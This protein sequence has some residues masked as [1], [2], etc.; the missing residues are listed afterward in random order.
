MA[1]LANM[2]QFQTGESQ[3][4]L[5]ME[6]PI[7]YFNWDQRQQ[8]RSCME[9]L[10]QALSED[11]VNSYF[12][13]SKRRMFVQGEVKGYLKALPAATNFI[14][15]ADSLAVALWQLL[16]LE[17]PRNELLAGWTRIFNVPPRLWGQL[18]KLEL[19]YESAHEEIAKQVGSYY[20]LSFI[21]TKAESRGK[22]YGSRLLSHIT[23][24]ADAEGRWCLLEAT[25]EMSQVSR[26]WGG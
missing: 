4:H 13:G 22:G 1:G 9:T 12:S 15:T 17:T 10:V 3:R 23:Q 6:Q 11:P 5:A 16:P 25:S 14:A 18:L 8:A 24:R 2:S 19:H 26:L 21:G 20:Y 7:C